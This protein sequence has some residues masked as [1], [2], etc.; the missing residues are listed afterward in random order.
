MIHKLLLRLLPLLL[1]AL[2]P[3]AS[4][5][6]LQAEEKCNATAAAWDYKGQCGSLYYGDAGGFQAAAKFL[7]STSHEA[8]DW[9]KEG[10]CNACMALYGRL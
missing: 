5:R 6:A 1:C 10:C 7:M 4:A 2:L 8:P 3:T 9:G